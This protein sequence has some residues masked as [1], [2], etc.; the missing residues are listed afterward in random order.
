MAR[1]RSGGMMQ[2]KII[3]YTINPFNVMYMAAR[4]CYS[5]TLLDGVD[6]TTNS[7]E[8]FVLKVLE[9]GHLSIAEHVNI[10]FGIE[11]I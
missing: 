2:V 9:S 1:V 3:S 8:E 5:Y 6:M 4:A 7:K 11:G 10:T